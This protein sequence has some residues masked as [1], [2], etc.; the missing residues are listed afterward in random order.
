MDKLLVRLASST[1]SRR[2]LARNRGGVVVAE[3]RTRTGGVGDALDKLR[4]LGTRKRVER[5]RPSQLK[6]GSVKR[7][8]GDERE[9]HREGGNDEREIVVPR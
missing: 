1:S 3:E 7:L 9:S 2:F 4:V 5:V 6:G 8:N